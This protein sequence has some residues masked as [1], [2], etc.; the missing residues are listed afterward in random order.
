M[1]VSRPFRRTVRQLLDGSYADSGNGRYVR[2]D[3]YADESRHFMRAFVAL[4]SDVKSLLE[5]IEPAEVNLSTYSLKLHGLMMRICIEVEANLRAIMQANSYNPS[6]QW[7][8][9][10]YKKVEKSHFLLYYEAR[11]PVWSGGG[12]TFVPFSGWKFN[13]GLAWYKD[14]NSAKHDRHG[15]FQKA[16]FGNVLQS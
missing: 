5:F 15:S 6:A 9:L 16:T 14:Y 11:L 2:H 13:G 3:R 12:G 4:D 1:G 7:S 10:D 8:M